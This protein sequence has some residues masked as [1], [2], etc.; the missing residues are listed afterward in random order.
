MVRAGVYILQVRAILFPKLILEE[1]LFII[2]EWCNLIE[3]RMKVTT[4]TG[5]QHPTSKAMSRGPKFGVWRL[6]IGNLKLS[7]N[8]IFGPI[9]WFFRWVLIGFMGF[10]GTNCA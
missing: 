2:Q 10:M 1:V 6:K 4:W 8:L 3:T 9:L 7:E 5:D